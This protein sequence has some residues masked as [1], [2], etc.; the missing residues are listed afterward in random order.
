MVGG[1]VGEGALSRAYTIQTQCLASTYETISRFPITKQG[2][3]FSV[4]RS[5]LPL[6]VPQFFRDKALPRLVAPRA[7][8]S[9][10]DLVLD[11]ID[12]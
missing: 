12:L 8:E 11:P 3:E 1:W 6:E 9:K 5:L 7:P 4:P 10:T 2:Q